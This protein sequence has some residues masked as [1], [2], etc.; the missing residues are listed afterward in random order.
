MSNLTLVWDF[1]GG[2]CSGWGLEATNMVLSLVGHVG[3]IGIVAGFGSWCKGLPAASIDA[4]EAM[5]TA[6]MNEWEVVDIFVSH[7][8]PQRYP[9]FPYRGVA[10]IDREPLFVIGRSMTEVQ[11]IS[12]EWSARIARLVDE[13]WVPARHS[14]ESFIAGGANPLQLRVVPEPIDAALYD[15]T[16][17]Q[18]LAAPGLRSFNFLSIFKLEERKGWKILIRAWME[19][20]SETDPVT[21]TLHTYLFNEADARNAR[22]IKQRVRE[23][24][25]DEL[26]FPGR[27]LTARP[28]PFANLIVH[29]EETD[30]QDMPALY[31]A[32]SA[33]VLPS[34]GEGWGMPLMEAMAMGSVGRA[35]TSPNA[36]DQHTS[37]HKAMVFKIFSVSP[38]SARKTR[39]S[40]TSVSLLPSRRSCPIRVLFP[41]VFPRFRPIGAGSWTSC[42]RATAT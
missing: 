4:L 41:A 10:H 14:H 27:N 25:E 35:S 31:A 12:R 7:K 19:E 37:R 21:L 1:G 33:F 9:T 29:A 30:T 26:E 20:F 28:L 2:G 3:R 22:R 32:Y 39:S 15:P 6:P 23:F 38:L 16:T 42:R 11:R 5:R 13:V 34:H 17:T 24:V 8:P 18:P 40:L 36:R